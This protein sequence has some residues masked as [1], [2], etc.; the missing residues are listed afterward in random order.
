MTSKTS[1]ACLA[2]GA[3]FATSASISQAQISA[4]QGGCNNPNV[5]CFG[6]IAMPA[7]AG[8]LPPDLAQRVNFTGDG[9]VKTFA[10]AL[11]NTR[12]GIFLGSS[13]PG[14]QTY[15]HLTFSFNFGGTNVGGSQAEFLTSGF[16]YRGLTLPAYDVSYSANLLTYNVDLD[17]GNLALPIGSFADDGKLSAINPV[18][19]VLSLAPGDLT[20]QTYVT[21]RNLLLGSTVTVTGYFNSAVPEPGAVALLGT[22][23]IG[24]GLTFWRYRRKR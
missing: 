8:E 3:I 2:I 14:Q 19:G 7:G 16:V 15:K 13:A 17:A 4:Q 23:F 10:G 11:L 1:F 21:N 9:S 12:E 18:Y 20:N 5:P 6:L 22:M 24:G